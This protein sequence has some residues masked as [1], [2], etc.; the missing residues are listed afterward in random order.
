MS[1]GDFKITGYPGIVPLIGLEPSTRVSKA[2]QDSG[3]PA[4]TLPGIFSFYNFDC[5]YSI[6]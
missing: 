3:K 1:A 5:T 2:D 6:A 4:T